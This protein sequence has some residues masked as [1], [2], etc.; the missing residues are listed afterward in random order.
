M[1]NNFSGI[2]F[3]GPK[4]IVF[5]GKMFFLDWTV[6]V[7]W[8]DVISVKKRH[9]GVRFEVGGANP[10]IYD[11]DGLFNPERAWS[12]LVSLHNDTIID[13]P[14]R[15]HE[16]PTPKSQSFRRTNSDPLRSSKTDLVFHDDETD[17]STDPDP[18][19]DEGHDGDDL[20]HDDNNQKHNGDDVE[21]TLHDNYDDD[22]RRLLQ[23]QNRSVSVPLDSPSDVVVK[24]DNDETTTTTTTATSSGSSTS[25]TITAPPPSP[26]E[27]AKLKK[28][29]SEISEDTRSYAHVAVQVRI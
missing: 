27:I 14:H 24:K 20:S 16:E 7:R 19:T 28:A 17:D 29:W 3:A 6:I 11:F 9:T 4:A 18:A 1:H 26:A 15:I 21:A 12:H 5:Q 8:E 13:S 25:P 22:P 23:Q 2:L 10:N